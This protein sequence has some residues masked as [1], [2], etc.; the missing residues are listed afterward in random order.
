MLVRA[1][2]RGRPELG[3]FVCFKGGHETSVCDPS[4]TRDRK[5][6]FLF[7]TKLRD[8]RRQVREVQRTLR[9]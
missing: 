5:L 2:L 7:P 4:V 9:R 6:K 8:E 1:I 3:I